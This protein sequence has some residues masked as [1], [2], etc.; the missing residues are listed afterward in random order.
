MFPTTKVSS[1]QVGNCTIQAV[2]MRF[3]DRFVVLLSTTGKVGQMF[4]IAHQRSMVRPVVRDLLP[5][6]D[7]DVKCVLGNSQGPKFMWSQL[8]ASQIASLLVHQQ[9]DSPAP[10]T[11]FLVGLH[12]PWS[13]DD[14]A[15]GDLV[16]AVLEKVAEQC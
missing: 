7:L 5:M 14:D 1:F 8:L 16:R 4:S 10:V 13:S 12:L 3:G 2:T 6:S 11:R 15:N 9:A